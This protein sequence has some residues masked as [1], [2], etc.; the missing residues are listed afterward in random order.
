MPT[1]VLSELAWRGQVH[2]VTD[3]KALREHLAIPRV[4]YCGFDPTADS[5]TIGNLV[6]MMLLR[7][8]KNAGHRVIVVVGGATGRIGDPSGKD[9]ERTLMTDAMV[10]S[11]IAGQRPSF[12]RVL[13]DDVEIID[14]YSWFRGMGFIQALRDIGKHFSIN[15]MVQRDSVRKRLEDREQGISYTEFS[16]MLLQAY[17]FLHLFREK[18]VTVQMAGSD[19]WGNIVSGV[20]LVRRAM[21]HG[22]GNAPLAFGLTAPLLTKADGGKFGKTEKGA[23]WLSAHRTSPYA[24]Y[25]FWINAE[26]AEVGKLLRIFTDLS[27]AEIEGIERAH[28]AAPQERSAQR[29]LAREAT[30][31]LHGDD[32]LARAEATTQALFSGDVAGLDAATIAE[33]FA[34]VPQSIHDRADLMPDGIAMADVVSQTTV[35]KSKREAKEF[36]AGGGVSVNGVKVGPEDRLTVDRL[37]HGRYALVR[38]G[39]KAWHVMTWD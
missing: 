34:G 23:V 32:A 20:D 24:Y 17:D 31:L 8:F 35:V 29:V 19:Q 3:E 1:D 27:R 14:N 28:A 4:V 37:L 26:D 38:R 9:A 12:Q 30:R 5:L 16:Y 22:E 13:G 39:K 33:A 6:P 15:A 25:Q 2:Q 36:L 10:E 11:N 21:G 18:R 7:R